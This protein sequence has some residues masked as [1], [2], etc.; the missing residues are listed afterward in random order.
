[1]KKLAPGVYD[2]EAGG[3]HLD[4]PEL[5]RAH[6]YADTPA[7]RAALIAA[8]SDVAPGIPLHTIDAPIRPQL[9][10]PHCGRTSYNPTD[11]RERYCG[12]CHVFLDGP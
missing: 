6:G 11:I 8:M 7:N 9:T 10:C 12:A 5:L 3:L 4:L 1:M 2:D